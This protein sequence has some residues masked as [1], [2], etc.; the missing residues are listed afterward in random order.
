MKLK[1]AVVLLPLLTMSLLMTSC[2]TVG[3][4]GPAGE[5]GQTGPKGDTGE[6]GP[7]GDKGDTGEQGPKGDKGDTGEQGESA[8]ELYIK[9]HPEYTFTRHLFRRSL[10]NR[11]RK[12]H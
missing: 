12:P 4:Q 9:N 6:Q 2:E 3:P 5:T 11:F 7:K 10:C 1:K 8:Y